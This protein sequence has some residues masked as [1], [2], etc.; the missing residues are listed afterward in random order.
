M[1]D[2]TKQIYTAKITRGKN[3][4]KGDIMIE[5]NNKKLCESCF[6]ETEE[7]IC[8]HCGFS[9]AEYS[10]DPLVLPMGTRLND[11]IVIGRVMGKGGFGVTYLGYDLRMDKTIAVKEYYPNGIAYR[12][13][14]GTEVA[15]ADTKSSETFD[16]GAEKFYAE[17]EMVAQFNGNPNI[18]SVYDYFRENNTVYLIMEYISGITL[19]NYVKKHG[20]LTDGQALFVM[21]KI[22]AAL[23]IT[24]SAGV[25]HRDISPDNIMICRDGKV[26][27][28][29]FGA[30]RQIM[31]ESSSNL[32]VVMKPGY[33]PIEQ[34]T[35]KGKQGAWTDIYSL[36]VS[37]Y[38]ALTEVIIDDPYA[39]MDDDSELDENK[40]G[41]NSDLWTILKKCTMINASDRYGSAIDLR[42]ALKSVSAPIKS[43]PINLTDDDLK[44]DNSSNAPEE[45]AEV[46]AEKDFPVTT[47][48]PVSE[49]TEVIEVFEEDSSTPLPADENTD[50]E[51]A[52]VT[53]SPDKGKAKIK[54]PML[55]GICA[56]AVA[57]AAIGIF[58]AVNNSG[59]DAITANSTDTTGSQKK[60]ITIDNNDISWSMTKS[61]DIS[62]LNEFDG[63][64]RVTLKLE[65]A[66]IEKSDNGGY[67]R[68]MKVLDKNNRFVNIN[69]LAAIKNNNSE[70]EVNDGDRDFIFVIP[71]NII[72]SINNYICFEQYNVLIKSAVLED[73][74]YDKVIDLDGNYPGDWGRMND[75]IPVDE[76]TCYDGDVRITLDLDMNILGGKNDLFWDDNRNKPMA[77][78]YPL[79][80]DEE[81]TKLNV[82]ADNQLPPAEGDMYP[83]VGKGEGH[84]SFT[85]SQEELKKHCEKRMNFQVYNCVVKKA[86]IEDADESRDNITAEA[87]NAAEPAVTTAPEVT[88]ANVTTTTEKNTTAEAEVTTIPKREEET[89]TAVPAAAVTTAA[90]TTTTKAAAT[91]T[92]AP[93]TTTTKATTTTTKATT[94]TTTMPEKIEKP[95]YIPLSTK[96]PGRWQTDEVNTIKKSYLKYFT[97]DIKVVL[98]LEC[99]YMN[100]NDQGGYWRN[101]NI[102]DGDRKIPVVYAVNTGRSPW[103]GYG[104]YD[105]QTKFT[106]IIKRAD[107]DKANTEFL[108]GVENVIVKGATIYDFDPKEDEINPKAKIIQLDS[109][110]PGTWN[111][112]SA[113]PKEELESFKGDVKV[114]LSIEA[115]KED[116]ELA[117]VDDKDVTIYWVNMDCISST[118][119][120]T[121]SKKVVIKA[122]NI[123]SDEKAIYNLGTTNVSDKFTFVIS[124]SEISKLYDGGLFFSCR[125][126]IVKSAAL[127]KA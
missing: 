73:N 96:Y 89:T 27:L 23:S 91:T 103:G 88:A 43:E 57:A 63:D 99:V 87:P 13:P 109:K 86:Y 104:I 22:A 7:E 8:P 84:F 16:S 80:D 44:S 41:V 51:E 11:K 117:Q 118:S 102:Y 39:R 123:V 122:D 48:A 74:T 78:I 125:N 112:S 32:T 95:L 68:S 47:A 60:I 52:V 76:L 5:I 10:A 64:I 92:T 97:G 85:I 114:T 106:F 54:K 119:S 100:K 94:T 56:A 116:G 75:G 21:D 50:A 98:D 45:P 24:H 81:W 19:K 46:S 126:V 79:S 58:A 35:K 34:Y 71:H 55:I 105:G 111:W 110:Y 6:C 59:S 29:D 93:P 121:D 62:T 25:L 18:V 17:A 14:S 127:E 70:F 28:I 115:V 12:L 9:A 101:I 69:A 15:V 124:R 33:T 83:L 108:F 107:I 61:I 66:N 1:S 77:F 82:S 113:I 38:Y 36:G 65:P 42:K 37:V 90:T 49:V 20:R 26:K 2:N 3:S 30:A 53:D 4:V 67:Y 40:H 120:F 31:A 72:G